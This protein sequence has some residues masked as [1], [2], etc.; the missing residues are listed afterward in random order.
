MAG[1]KQICKNCETEFNA[2]FNFCPNCG[3]KA[4]D[5]LTIGVL[6]YNTISNY[7]SF[8][9]RFFKSVIPL[10][11][12]PGYLAK[13]FVQGKRLLYLHP[14]QLYLFVSVIFFFILSI[15]VVNRQVETLD[16]T[17]QK[18][19]GKP[20]FSETEENLAKLVDTA[21]VDSVMQVLKEKNPEI[22]KQ[23]N[24]KS[25]D[26]LIKAENGNQSLKK[27]FTWG[28]DQKKIDSLIA[29]D[30]PKSEI[31][32]AMGMSDDASWFSKKIH[33]QL[34]K[35]YKQRNGG[36][37]LKA[38]YDT[39]PISL[40]ILLPIFA[41]LLK[42]FFYKRGPYAYHLVFSFYFYSFLFTVFSIMLIANEI[43]KIP[44][45]INFLFML[46]TF[47]YLLI[48][49]KRFYEKGWF[50]SFF[51]T[52]LITGIY[53]LFVIPIAAIILTLVGFMSF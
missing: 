41:L 17:L 26:S 22:A 48:A 52:S 7:F 13:T 15:T 10:L 33:A 44:G 51:K 32:K 49:V 31:Y 27:G 40:F 9:A 8:D 37:L 29:I 36:Q 6:F 20:L 24:L 5:D 23:T 38:V 28:F 34:L 45:F 1:E 11:L 43:V 50:N 35:L 14:A 18:T 42:M 19:A 4:K 47:I 46:S 39:I 12:K 21:Q 3:Q 53:F 30:A 25:I 2:D 16:N